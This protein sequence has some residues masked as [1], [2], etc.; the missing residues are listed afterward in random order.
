MEIPFIKFIEAL[1]ACKY[2]IDVI[3]DRVNQLGV[4]LADMFPREAIAQVYAKLSS[5][6]PEY[7]KN[8]A[9][10][11]DPEWLRELGIIKLVAYELKLQISET[12]VGVQGAFE[13]I[14]DQN[15]YETMSALALAK[16]TDED[17]ELIVNGKY[18]IHYSHEDIKEFLRYF[19][20]VEGWSL[21]QKK[22]YVNIV[23]D[24]RLVGLYNLALEGDKDYLIWKL[25][26]APDKSFDQ[27]IKDMSTDAYYNFK[28]KMKREPEEA[29]KWGA[30]MLRLSDKLD[31]LEKD[32]E[33]KKDLFSQ[34]T[35][36]LSGKKEEDLME[37][38]IDGTGTVVKS[39]KLKRKHISELTEE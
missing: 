18:N 39:K 23:K 30:L 15:M 21:S 38:V 8:V 19:F 20:N 9:G 17:I 2:P 29:Q 10:V 25:G 1:V 32:T 4:T 6:A 24:K 31:R 22:E 35:F 26:I 37:N 34:V 36:V 16:V 33:E 3:Y 7:F 14:K 13:I 12:T 5:I 11:P 28:E 27:M